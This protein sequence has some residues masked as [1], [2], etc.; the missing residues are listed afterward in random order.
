MARS[1]AAASR[2]LLSPVVA[3]AG[4][5]NQTDNNGSAD[6][7]ACDERES[8]IVGELPHVRALFVV[9][10]VLSTSLFLYASTIPLAFGAPH[11]FGERL[12]GMIPVSANEP[13]QRFDVTANILAFI[14]IGFVWCGALWTPSPGSNRRQTMRRVAL[15]CLGF[16]CL[17]ETIQFWLPLRVPSVRDIAA[18]ETGA[19]LGCGLWQLVGRNTTAMLCE[20]VRSVSRWGGRRTGLVSWTVFVAVIF[21]ICLTLNVTGNSMVCFRMYSQRTLVPNGFLWQRDFELSSISISMLATVVIVGLCRLGVRAAQLSAPRREICLVHSSRERKAWERLSSPERPAP[22]SPAPG[23]LT[24]EF[25]APT[26]Q[27]AA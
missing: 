13:Q 12:A 18:L 14:P 11:D 25:P 5:S 10:A 27:R 15:S 20:A 1:T 22:E 7:H 2:R 23:S 24:A 16:A 17:A 9:A 19:L 3:P 26:Q 6:Y 8:T 4:A 21:T